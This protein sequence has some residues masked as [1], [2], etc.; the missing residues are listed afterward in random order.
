MEYAHS[1]TIYT[2]THSCNLS[3]S[4]VGIKSK[5]SSIAITKETTGHTDEH[6][7]LRILHTDAC[8]YWSNSYEYTRTLYMLE[9]R[10][11]E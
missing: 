8:M 5:S 2:A 11:E 7:K 9:A 6:Y 4:A 1:H 3:I 10:E